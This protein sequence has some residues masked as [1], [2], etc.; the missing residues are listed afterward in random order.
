VRP[1]RL[2][3]ARAPPPQACAANA[4]YFGAFGR[5]DGLDPPL[6]WTPLDAVLPSASSSF[7]NV[8]QVITMPIFAYTIVLT[9]PRDP[10]PWILVQGL[11]RSTY[12]GI[13]L[14]RSARPWTQGSDAERRC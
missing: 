14:C 4:T 11:D 6:A 9:C 10:R 2:T 12:Y 7:Y 5:P 8:L 1:R 13:F 3:A